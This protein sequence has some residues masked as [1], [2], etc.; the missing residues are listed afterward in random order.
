MTIPVLEM[1]S[2]IESRQNFVGFTNNT[3]FQSVPLN[4]MISPRQEKK[5]VEFISTTRIIP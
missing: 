4:T 3:P 2:F 5:K 1:A